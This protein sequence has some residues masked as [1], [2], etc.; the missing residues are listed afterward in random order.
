MSSLSPSPAAVEQALMA[1]A[2]DRQ[3]SVLQ[4][5]FK[6]GPG[7]YGEGDVFL[8]V[9]VPQVRAVVKLVSGQIGLDHIPV[10][11]HSPY[12]EVRLA[13]FLLLVDA[14]KFALRSARQASC[15]EAD[16]VVD[17]YLAHSH[18]ANNWDLVDLSAPKVLGR[19]LLSPAGRSRYP[20]C[21]ILDSLSRSDV[22]WQQ[23]IA[24]V[25]TWTLIRA[26]DY[27][28]TLRLAARLLSHRHDLMHKAVGWMLREVGKRDAAVLRSFLHDH[29]TQMPRTALRYAIERLAPSERKHW[30]SV[31]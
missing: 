9:R 8:G 10:L 16:A 3:R 1:L 28:P 25:S 20:H 13:G 6:T 21:E 7:Q 22:L 14:M 31:R 24:I 30:L 5:F 4:R 29:A 17:C 23:R 15:V 2:D 26:D 18:L 27:A 12:H 19:Y 11:L